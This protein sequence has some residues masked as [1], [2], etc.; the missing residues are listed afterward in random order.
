M[1]KAASIFFGLVSWFLQ[2]RKVPRLHYTETLVNQINAA[3]F[4]GE[5][6][7]RSTDFPQSPSKAAIR[8]VLLLAERLQ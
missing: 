4:S 6:G 3:W 2:G 7:P 1:S 5:S 8:R